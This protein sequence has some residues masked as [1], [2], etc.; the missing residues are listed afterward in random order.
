MWGSRGDE[1]AFTLVKGRLAYPDGTPAGRALL[2]PVGAV[3]KVRRAKVQFPEN[4]HMDELVRDASDRTLI[5][6]RK[7]ATHSAPARVD[8]DAPDGTPIGV[9]AKSKGW[10]R[11]TYAI[12]DAGNRSVGEIR[13]EKPSRHDPRFR[14]LLHDRSGNVVGRIAQCTWVKPGVVIGTLTHN[15]RMW[16]EL[17]LHAAA[18]DDLRALVVGFLTV[19]GAVTGLDIDPPGTGEDFDAAPPR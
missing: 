15:H 7:H 2:R 13:E 11:K 10:I 5:T 12:T 8:I 18:D 1:C 9:V 17:E 4:E 6:V 3:G 14:A 19:Y 16:W